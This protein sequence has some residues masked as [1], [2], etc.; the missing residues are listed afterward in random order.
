MAELE[1]TRRTV[2]TL[3]PVIGGLEA[4]RFLTDLE[5][6]LGE[7]DDDARVVKTQDPE[8]RFEGT[9]RYQGPADDVADRLVELWTG[10]LALGDRQAHRIRVDEDEVVLE[11][12][13]WRHGLGVATG[14]VVAERAGR[15]MTPLRIHPEDPADPS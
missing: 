14:R 12:L 3:L 9:L 1:D 7:I 4:E 6:A 15:G 2:L 10:R 5:W 13:T 8:C 11:F